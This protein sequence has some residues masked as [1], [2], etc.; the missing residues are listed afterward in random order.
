MPYAPDGDLQGAS[1][2]LEFLVA[3]VEVFLPA[4]FE[5]DGAEG[6]EGVVVVQKNGWGAL[7][8]RDQGLR[9]RSECIGEFGVES[10][11]RERMV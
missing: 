3:F 1:P 2:L 9:G 5:G 6:G 7:A 8:E 11:R 10:Q 4:V